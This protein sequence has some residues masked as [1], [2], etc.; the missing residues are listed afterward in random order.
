MCV[1]GGGGSYL[2]LIIVEVLNKVVKNA[3]QQGDVQGISLFGKYTQQ[4]ISKYDDHTSFPS[5]IRETNMD[6]MLEIMEH[7]DGLV[8]DAHREDSPLPIFSMCSKFAPTCAYT[9]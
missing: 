2:I 6:N 3:I 1:G 5:K 9:T 4:V 8:C 7:P